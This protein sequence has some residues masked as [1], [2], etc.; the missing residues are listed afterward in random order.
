MPV[1]A[2]LYRN[3]WRVPGVSGGDVQENGRDVGVSKL[4]S[5]QRVGE[6]K[7]SVCLCSRVYG[8]DRRGVRGLRRRQVQERERVGGVR[9]LCGDEELAGGG[10]ERDELRLQRRLHAARERGPDVRRRV[11]TGVRGL[12]TRHVQGA[13]GRSSVY[14]LRA[15]PVVG[16]CDDSVLVRRGIHRARRGAVRRMCER[17]V[18]E[19]ARSTGVHD[20]S[21]EFVYSFY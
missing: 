6:R 3:T 11:R 9:R 19:L 2:G 8:T 1:Q 12:C 5:E 10:P 18:Q 15:E 14:Y 16:R 4:S 7:C 21:S 20:M 17:H 13:D